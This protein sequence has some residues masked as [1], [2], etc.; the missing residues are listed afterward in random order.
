[1]IL[2]CQWYRPGISSAL[3][4]VV[5]SADTLVLPDTSLEKLVDAQPLRLIRL[6]LEFP[7]PGN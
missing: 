6:L 7:I 3:G 1:M 2:V 5:Y 4:C